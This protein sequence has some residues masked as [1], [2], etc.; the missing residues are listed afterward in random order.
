M[1]PENCFIVAQILGCTA[2]SISTY[3]MAFSRKERSLLL[4]NLVAVLL[5]SA[6]FLVLDRHVS[7]ATCFLAAFTLFIFTIL[8]KHPRAKSIATYIFIIG[9]TVITIFLYQD[10]Y[11]FIYLIGGLVSTWAFGHMSACN[12]STIRR[13]K[14]M[15]VI[16][17]CFWLVFSTHIDSPIA[18]ASDSLWGIAAL[19]D[20]I[21][22]Y[23]NIKFADLI[24]FVYIE[25]TESLY[26]HNFNY[27]I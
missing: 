25:T 20:T 24:I 18:I 6:H 22:F 19:F 23:K 8:S 9:Q 2:I 21:Y 14:F 4:M 16:S 7:S 5:W 27:I 3:A 13:A 17:S 12:I 1:S 11:D 26:L 10:F 15:N